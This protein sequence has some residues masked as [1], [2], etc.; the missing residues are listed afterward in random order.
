MYLTQKGRLKKKVQYTSM[1]APTLQPA[2][3]SL[4]QLY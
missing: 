1:Y 2:T 4:F 3:Y